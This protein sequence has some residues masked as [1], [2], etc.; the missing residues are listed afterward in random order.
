ML[1]KK[2]QLN[3]EVKPVNIGIEGKDMGIKNTFNVETFKNK[4]VQVMSNAG[5]LTYFE[6]EPVQVQTVPNLIHVNYMYMDSVDLED[7]HIK[8]TFQ[9][10]F[11][12]QSVSDLDYAN[13]EKNDP[14]TK[15]K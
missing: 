5:W 7:D 4:L 13:I 2:L 3:D 11:K 8:E 9:Q 15:Q 1:H 12:N 14:W 10:V 6:T